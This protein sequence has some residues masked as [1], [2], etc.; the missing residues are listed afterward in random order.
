MTNNFFTIQD[1]KD[2]EKFERFLK[3]TQKELS[4]FFG[5]DIG[6]PSVFFIQSRKQYDDIQKK[7]SQNWMVG[8][9]NSN[10]IFILNP[11]IYT[12]ESDHKDEKSFWKVLKHEYC[13]MAFSQLCK[14]NKPAWLNEGLACYFADQVKENLTKEDALKVF[15]YYAKADSK[16]YGIG[17]FWVKLLIEKFG[18]EKL[19]KLLKEFHSG[20]TEEYFA[21]L[22]KDVYNVSFSKTGLSQLLKKSF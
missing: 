4:G 20:L 16:I 1:I 11:K 3:K 17:Y 5:I 21:K 7:K 12:K 13:H 9:A 19:F 2:S 15:E 18:K 6:F 14:Y 10:Y 8:W 22:F